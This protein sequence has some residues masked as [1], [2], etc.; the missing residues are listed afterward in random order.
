[1]TILTRMTRLL[2]ADMN[3]LLDQMEAPDVLLKQALREMQSELELQNARLEQLNQRRQR[4]SREIDRSQ[5]EQVTRQHGLQLCL[6]QKNDDLARSIL[7]KQL[8]SEQLVEQMRQQLETC[9]AEW[10]EAAV[11][12]NRQQETLAQL[13]QQAALLAEPET[14][15]PP[16]SRN[17]IS[18]A[19]V[20]VELLKARAKYASDAEG[21]AL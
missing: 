12:L 17:G 10:N 3:A 18:E 20:E 11:C 8:E 15:T 5:A 9:T 14:G 6:Q 19:D 7:R 2:K 21:E 4:L 16:L 1:M 13:R